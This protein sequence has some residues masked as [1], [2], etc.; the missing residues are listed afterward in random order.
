MNVGKN[1][2]KFRK[3]KNLTQEELAKKINVSPKTISSYENN[4]N[5]PTIETLLLLSQVLEVSIDEIVGKT[6]KDKNDTKEKYDKQ[7]KNNLLMIF[8][9]SLFT[10][11]IFCIHEFIVVYGLVSLSDNFKEYLSIK[12][13]VKLILQNG[14]IYIV[15]VIWFYLMYYFKLNEKK[16]VLAII[17]SFIIIAIFAIL[18][19]ELLF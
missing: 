19:L 8:A 16:P 4:R 12:D 11:C 6:N 18:F 1:I 3:E 17:L 7:R 2:A 9:I 10:L 13:V 5:L 14:L 15:S